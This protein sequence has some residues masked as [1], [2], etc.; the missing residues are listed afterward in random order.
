MMMARDPTKPISPKDFTVTE[1]KEFA[2]MRIAPGVLQGADFN[3]DLYFVGC[4][5]YF[6]TFRV[7][8]R[9]AFCFHFAYDRL[10]ETDEPKGVFIHCEKGNEAD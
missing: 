4:I 1:L 10:R 6:D 3:I 7:A 5:N 2:A 9:T 8:H